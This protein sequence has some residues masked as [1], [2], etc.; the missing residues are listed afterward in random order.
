MSSEEVERSIRAF[1][2]GSG[3]PWDWDDFISVPLRDSTLDAVRVECA[4]LPERFPPTAPGCYCSDAGM[5][6]L[7]RLM[8]TLRVQREG[9]AGRGA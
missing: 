8:E 2:D 6:E 3:E 7:R 9:R 4:R 5:L 1:L